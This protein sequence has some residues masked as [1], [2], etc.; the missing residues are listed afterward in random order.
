MKRGSSL[1]LVHAFSL[2]M[3]CLDAASRWIVSEAWAGQGQ[4]WGD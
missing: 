1:V 3:H 4:G 2:L